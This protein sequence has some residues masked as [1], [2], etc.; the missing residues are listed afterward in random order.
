M[1]S[2]AKDKNTQF[3][4]GQEVVYP[5]QGV[6]RVNA[7]EEKAFKD[8]NKVIPYLK[9]NGLRFVRAFTPCVRI[10]VASTNT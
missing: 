9:A 5:L 3:K 1:K 7:I 4:V 8:K 10:D 6:G 2:A